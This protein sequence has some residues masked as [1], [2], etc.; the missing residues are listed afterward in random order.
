M[1]KKLTKI[2]IEQ[3]INKN[4]IRDLNESYIELK[5]I[6]YFLKNGN[7]R[8]KLEI[9]YLKKDDKIIK[10]KIFKEV[11]KDIREEIGIV[12]GSFLTKNFN[13]KD[14]YLESNEVTQLLNLHKST[15]ERVEFYEEIY[16]RIFEWYKP[17]KIAD[18]A[19]G[20]NPIS[21]S[22]I[23]DILK[24]E[25]KYFVSDLNPSDMEFLNKF[26]KKNNFN[27]TARNY[28]ITQLKILEDKNYQESDLVF[29]FKALDSFEFVKKNISKELLEKTNSNHIVVSFP[30]KS[31]FSKQE[32]KIE[33]RNWF[34]NY[35]NK[36]EWNYETF[37]VE[38][39]LFILITKSTSS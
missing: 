37:E 8:K 2:L 9:N 11:L 13:K 27:A 15:R 20:L 36:M 6:N 23:K 16:N 24:S 34:F 38:N 18:I 3:I 35:L 33:K 4:Q 14:K 7:I 10:S 31:L 30:T 39:E 5:L 12:Y 28:D 26:F 19:C 22:M 32:F 17:N 29:M 21:Y 1:N 25:P